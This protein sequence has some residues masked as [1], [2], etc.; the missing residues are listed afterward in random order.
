MQTLKRMFILVMVMLLTMPVWAQVEAKPYVVTG[1]KPVNARSCPR[2]DCPVVQSIQ[3]GETVMVVDTVTGALTLGSSQWYKVEM[4]GKTMYIHSKLIKAVAP[5]TTGDT[6]K[7]IAVDISNWVKVK[8]SG[9]S[10]LIPDNWLDMNELLEDKD[11]LSG[12]AEMQGVDA[13]QLRS[14]IEKMKADGSVLFL[15]LDTGSFALFAALDIGSSNPKPSLRMLK[16]A[17]KVGVE[18]IGAKN[19]SDKIVA[20]PGGD[21]ARLLFSASKPIGLAPKGTEFLIYM[22]LNGNS[23]YMFTFYSSQK[24]SDQQAVIYDAVVRSATFSWSNANT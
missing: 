2:V 14:Q 8:G 16:A 5:V 21:C 24:M 6:S 3:P 10:L 12:L 23:A 17:I 18:K 20:L 22:M 15:D 4:D 7:S 19:L 11:F 9:F 1:N 13:D